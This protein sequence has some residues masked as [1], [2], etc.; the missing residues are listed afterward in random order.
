MDIH[1]L[2]SYT[3]SIPDL[4]DV[5]KLAASLH[6]T[7][8][9]YHDHVW[10]WEVTY[11]PELNEA[12]AEVEVPDGKGGYT[13]QIMSLWTPASFVIGESG[14]WFFSLLWEHG[15]DQEPVAFLD[16]RNVLKKMWTTVKQ[17]WSNNKRRRSND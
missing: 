8:Q 10:G 13:T 14:V 17:S 1:A 12:D 6:A 4:S 5:Q 9:S 3:A 16:D 15:V 2:L 7:G 11:E